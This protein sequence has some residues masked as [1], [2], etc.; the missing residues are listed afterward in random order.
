MHY[1]SPVEK[2]PLLEV[3][4]TPKTADW[5]VVTATSLGKAQ[6]KTVIVVR[7]GPGFYTSRILAPYMNEA[8]WLLTEGAAV[9]EI[10][11]ALVEFGYPVGPVT[12]LDEVGIDVG[13]K[14]ANIMQKRVRRAHAGAGCRRGVAP[15]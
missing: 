5:A 3:V 11:A 2:M 7:D 10:D 8:M 4:V 13:A 12:L 6:G 9:D 15:R 1:F 14:V